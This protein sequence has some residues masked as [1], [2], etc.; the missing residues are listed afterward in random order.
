[1]LKNAIKLEIQFDLLFKT[2]YIIQIDWE[3]RIE[4]C[5]ARNDFHERS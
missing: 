2:I 1:M 3:E 4:G 5:E